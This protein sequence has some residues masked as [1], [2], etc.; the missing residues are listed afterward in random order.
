[1]HCSFPHSYAAVSISFS[2]T[3]FTASES[4]GSVTVCLE[5]NRET[6]VEIP[7]TLTA[8]SQGISTLHVILLYVYSLFCLPT[9]SLGSGSVELVF[10]AGSDNTVC[11]DWTIIDNTLSEGDQTISISLSIPSIPGV[12]A[13]D[14]PVSTILITDDE[15]S[16]PSGNPHNISTHSPHKAHTHM[17]TG[18]FLGNW[19]IYLK[20]QFCV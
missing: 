2:D 13:G 1:M 20:V 19:G 10:P 3:V 18:L 16:Q 8:A 14:I 12:M 7:I 5:K 17:I 9:G 11:T 15:P 6:T 4:S